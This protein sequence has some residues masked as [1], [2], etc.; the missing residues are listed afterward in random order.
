MKLEE[1]TPDQVFE[2]YYENISS[3][4]HIVWTQI[5]E[6][7]PGRQAFLVLEHDSREYYVRKYFVFDERKPALSKS[8]SITWM[9]KDNISRAEAI[10]RYS[11]ILK[12]EL[13]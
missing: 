11:V 12:E 10:M 1:M 13:N 7:F 3:T 4:H 2:N 9:R 8:G 5:P 6:R